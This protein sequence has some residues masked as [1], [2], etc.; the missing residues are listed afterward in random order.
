MVAE[1]EGLGRVS[2]GLGPLV[3]MARSLADAV[4][5]Q[6]LNAAL[7]REYRGVVEVLKEVAESD[8]VTFAGIVAGLRSE[9]PDS[10]D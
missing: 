8:D 9:V 4:D 1:L 7:W 3:Q 2:L 10:G 6:P 5:A